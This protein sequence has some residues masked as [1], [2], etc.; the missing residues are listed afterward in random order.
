MQ[1][2]VMMQYPFIFH[3][4]LIY[5][6]FVL[7]RH[8]AEVMCQSLFH[9]ISGSNKERNCWRVSWTCKRCNCWAETQNH[10]VTTKN[11]SLTKIH[12]T[13]GSAMET[14]SLAS[15]ESGVSQLPLP[16]DHAT[17]MWFGSEVI[18]ICEDLLVLSIWSHQTWENPSKVM[19]KTQNVPPKKIVT[20]VILGPFSGSIGV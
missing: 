2:N 1:A 17:L 18:C 4:M 6:G 15:W 20:R 3:Y 13:C 19:S 14:I 11:P 12:P 10:T 7:R 16:L 5:T 9:L 8:S